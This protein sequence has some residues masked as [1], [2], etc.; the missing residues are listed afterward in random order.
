MSNDRPTRDSMSVEEATIS[1][2]WEIAGNGVSDPHLIEKEESMKKTGAEA[3]VKSRSAW[4]V[5]AEALAL[6]LG[7]SAK[8]MKRAVEQ[9][10]IQHAAQSLYDKRC[11]DVLPDAVTTVLSKRPKNTT[12]QHL[13]K[14]RNR[15]LLGIS[16]AK[17]RSFLE[18]RFQL[19]VAGDCNPKCRFLSPA[20]TPS[21]ERLGRGLTTD[22]VLRENRL[23][24][25]NRSD[26]PGIFAPP[27]M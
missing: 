27:T 15:P 14:L 11:R 9:L 20:A 3:A 7:V 21:F 26:K 25:T 8:K 4:E 16:R 13:K 22:R 10:L 2:M 1:N 23:L 24:F 18:S 5:E 19:G 17:R 6:R 12:N